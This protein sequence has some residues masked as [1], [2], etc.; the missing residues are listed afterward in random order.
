MKKFAVIGL[1]K[2]GLHVAK[3][4]FEDGHEVIAIDSEKAR[5]QAINS[6][7]S[8]AVVMDATDRLQISALGLESLDAVIVSTGTNI[9]SSILIC[10]HL[11]EIGVKK[12]I[13]KAVD[14]D[15][16]KILKKVGASEVVYPEK[17]M[18][19]RVARGLSTPNIIDFIP[20]AE[21]FTLVQVDPPRGFIGKSLKELNLR[22]KHNV[23]IIAIKELV[24]ENFVLAP[25]ANFV[26]KDSDV[27]MMLGKTDD[28]KKIKALN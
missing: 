9:S 18:A 11:Q 16:G 25:P 17:D 22:A 5:V 15:H 26:I 8:E 21:E 1:G 13:A 6:D 28:I 27:L 12:I 4:L 3:T 10:L 14:S 24:P 20:L 7:C 19:V 2:F 23:Y